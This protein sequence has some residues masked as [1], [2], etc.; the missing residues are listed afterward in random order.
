MV[1]A[2]VVP[3]CLLTVAG[4]AG[5]NG[6]VGKGSTDVPVEKI[7]AEIE[8]ELG[9]RDD[10]ASV[11]VHYSDSVTVSATASVDVTM[12]PGAD[13]HELND[14]ALRLV[15]QSKLNPLSVISVSVID[16]VTPLNGV[17]TSVNLF[18]DAVRAPLERAYGP[19][20]E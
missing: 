9:Q 16:P 1:T 10:V 18:E 2:A 7:S 11:D 14:E 6:A 5:S 8:D 19:H 17:S 3:L 12:K 13:P 15:W 4:C 20:P